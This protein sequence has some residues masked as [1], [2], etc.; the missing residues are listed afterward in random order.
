MRIQKTFQAKTSQADHPW[1]V[2]DATNQVVGRMASQVATLLRG[3]HS[4]RYTPHIDMGAFVVVINAEKVRFT[5]KKWDEKIYW[6]HSGYIGGIKSQTAA[7]LLA[8]KPT[9][10]LYQ[11]VQGMLPKNVLGRKLLGKLKVY[12]GPDHPHQAQKPQLI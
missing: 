6:R 2:L 7:E 12:A 11:A 9:E 4:P 5:G 1:Y 10:I 8:K 3:K